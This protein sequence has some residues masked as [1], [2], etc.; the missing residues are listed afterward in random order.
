MTLPDT[1]AEATLLLARLYNKRAREYR[2]LATPIARE[3][4]LLNPCLLYTSGRAQG[5]R[6]CLPVSAIL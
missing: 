5:R 1:K 3:A 6:R 4:L 2:E